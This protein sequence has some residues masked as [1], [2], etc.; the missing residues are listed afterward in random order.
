MKNCDDWQKMMVDLMEQELTP[1]QKRELVNHL[2][3]CRLCAG[4][5]DR[6]KKLYKLMDEDRIELPPREFFESAL[7]RLE[8]PRGIGEALLALVRQVVLEGLV[9]LADEIVHRGLPTPA[10]ASQS[11]S[12]AARSTPSKSPRRASSKFSA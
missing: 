8:G 10:G 4:E 1:M 3:D 9:G 2:G 12:G 7:E 5:Y 6:L 11:R